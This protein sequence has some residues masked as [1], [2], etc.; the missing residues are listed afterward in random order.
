MMWWLIRKQIQQENVHITGGRSVYVKYHIITSLYNWDFDEALK[1]LVFSPYD[2][3]WR[4]LL[5]GWAAF[6]CPTT[7]YRTYW[8]W[9]IFPRMYGY[10]LAWSLG[11][12]YDR[13]DD[14]L[15][16]W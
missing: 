11:L 12:Y 1:K 10:L 7:S 5:F 8:S 13:D 15:Y 6:F 3:W 9:H 14:E 2:S 4:L 16:E